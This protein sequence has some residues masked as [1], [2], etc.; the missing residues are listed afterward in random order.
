M[1]RRLLSLLLCVC[2]TLSCTSVFAATYESMTQDAIDALDKTT[3]LKSDDSPTGYYVTFRYK[4]PEAT[5]VRIYGEWVFSDLEHATAFTGLNATPDEWQNGYTVFQVG[6][7]PTAD[8]TLNQA[9]GVWSYTIPLPN[10]TY[11]YRYYVGGVDGAELTDY[12]DAVMV[13]DPVNPPYLADPNQTELTKE[14]CTSAVYVPYD[15]IR[16]S[17]SVCVEEQAPRE[18]ETGNVVYDTVIL[19]DG[20]ESTYAVYLPYGFD[21]NR[22]EA[23]PVLVMY[24]GGGGCENSWLNNGLDHIMDNMIAEGRLE[25][26]I[27]VLPDGSDMPHPDF[28]WDHPGLVAVAINDLLPHMVETY[29]VSEDPARRAIGGLSHG[30]A[31][32]M[33]AYFHNTDQFAYY[34]SMSAPLRYDVDPV[35]DQAG[36]NDVKLHFSFGMYDTIVYGPLF[37]EKTAVKYGTA[38]SFIYGLSQAGVDFEVKTDL[39][40]GHQWSLWREMAVY[41]FDN[42]LWK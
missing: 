29:H 36:L 18:S 9:T 32:V 20:T 5:R 22:S 8:M 23:Y 12:T 11:T 4:D 1:N 42:V 31:C 35:Y 26:T 34:L 2:L 30:A 21:V 37:N 19:P 3:V 33:N 38:Y 7:W 40:Y 41:T 16:Q 6:G 28:G 14:E 27:V 17:I 39:P 25:P 13:F 15:E 10:G 24:H